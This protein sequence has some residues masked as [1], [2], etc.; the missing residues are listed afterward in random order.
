MKRHQLSAP[1]GYSLIEILVVVGLIGVV[2]A[3]A[4]PMMSN[5]LGFFRLSGD[6]RSI[7]NA[8]AVAK[9][10]A[11][12]DFSRVRLY[13]DLSTQSHHIESWDKVNS[14]W[15]VEGGSTYLSSNVV[16]G[17]G[18]V[19]TAPPN[20]QATIAQAPLC[21]DDLGVAIGNTACLMFNSRGVPVDNTFSPT[22][23][24]ALYLT[25]GSAVYA[26]TAAATG[27]IRLWRTLP[28]ATPSWVLN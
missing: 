27:M 14:K 4:V 13:V 17:F 22:A 24:D 16:F 9:M 11:A 6:A 3:I 2:G 15:V 18:A 26:V 28:T 5:T 21:T 1:R 20:T 8:T 7:S 12:S 19:T 25:D 10:R 23:V